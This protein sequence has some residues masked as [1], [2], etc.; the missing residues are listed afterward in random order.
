MLNGPTWVIKAGNGNYL[1]EFDCGLYGRLEKLQWSGRQMFAFRFDNRNVA[2]SV[3]ARLGAA[4]ASI[5]RLVRTP[6]P[7]PPSSVANEGE[8]P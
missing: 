8:K 5:V 2:T 3:A 1:I 4:D 6:R 7:P